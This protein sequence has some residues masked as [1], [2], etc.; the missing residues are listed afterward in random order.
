MQVEEGLQHIQHLSHLCE[1]EGL[2]PTCL[3]LVQQLRQLLQHTAP[4][5]C[6]V[7]VQEQRL[8][9]KQSIMRPE[10]PNSKLYRPILV[11]KFQKFLLAGASKNAKVQTPGHIR[12]FFGRWAVPAL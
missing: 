1:D 7:P 5:L 6:Q 8:T 9:L 4:Q 11:W 10:T 2:M 3:Q 12:A